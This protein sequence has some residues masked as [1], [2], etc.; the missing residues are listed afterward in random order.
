MRAPS[1]HMNRHIP[2]RTNALIPAEEADAHPGGGGCTHPDGGGWRLAM[3]MGPCAASIRNCC[4]LASSVA[5]NTAS[6]ALSSAPRAFALPC[7]NCC[8]CA[9]LINRGREREG[10]AGRGAREG[11]REGGVGGGE[12]GREG[13][14]EWRAIRHASGGKHTARPR[15]RK[16]TTSRSSLQTTRPSGKHKRHLRS[17]QR[18]S[19]VLYDARIGT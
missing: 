9:S 13:R 5:W 2:T 7:R 16:E 3:V 18:N 6:L 4:I 14:C 17:L 12:G 11:G 10:Q 8:C 15:Y 1:R 19:S